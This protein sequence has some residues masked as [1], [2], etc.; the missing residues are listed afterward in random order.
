MK[1]WI[2]F[3][4]IFIGVLVFSG[5]Q[6]NTQ[7]TQDT[8]QVS[9][10]QTKARVTIKLNDMGKE[11][12]SQKIWYQSND[13]LLQTLKNHFNVEE[14][15]GFITSIEN[16]A[17]DT[18]KNKYWTFTINGKMSEKGAN[19]IKLKNKDQVVFDLNEFKK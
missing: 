9:D 18:N 10:E 7:T 16:H 1:R 13:T 14:K 17:Q 6:L 8:K 5:C 11:I 19:E 4:T 15:N 2:G 3:L 12:T